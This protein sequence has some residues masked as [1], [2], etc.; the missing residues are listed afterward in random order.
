M[1]PP[2]KRGVD[3]PVGLG[4]LSLTLRAHSDNERSQLIRDVLQAAGEADARPRSTGIKGYPQALDVLDASA[5]GWTDERPREVHLTLKQRDCSWERFDALMR[6]ADRC[7]SANVARLDLNVDDRARVATPADVAAACVQRQV[8]TRVDAQHVETHGHGL[9]IESVYIGSRASDR[10]LNVYDKD[11]EQAHALRRPV[12][13]GT[14][15]VRWELRLRADRAAAAAR[16][17]SSRRD[18]AAFWHLVLQ[19]VDFADRPS[20]RQHGRRGAHRLT[21]FAALV[22]D[23]SRDVPY[24][25]R[26]LEDP[27]VRLAR[28][29]GW[30]ARQIARPLAE[31]DEHYSGRGVLFVRELLADGYSRLAERRAR[32]RSQVAAA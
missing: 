14:Y 10:H 15:G 21:W 8:V 9:A 5:V 28:L 7:E 22:G 19:L 23:Q 11:V 16:A 25:P 24:G 26:P 31:V 27:D 4:W 30:L 17:F 29:Q 6:L 1:T 32:S 12:P 2:T 13:L 18:P 3:S 20:D